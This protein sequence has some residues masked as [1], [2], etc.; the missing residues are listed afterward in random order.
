[1]LILCWAWHDGSYKHLN[2]VLK[3][4]QEWS[5]D[6]EQAVRM[7]KVMEDGTPLIIYEWRQSRISLFLLAW[8]INNGRSNKI[9]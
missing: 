7:T 2:L 5:M 9:C 6:P 4:I 1:M 3:Q 8:L